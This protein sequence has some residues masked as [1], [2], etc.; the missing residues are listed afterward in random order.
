MKLLTL[1]AAVALAGCAAQ[2]SVQSSTPRS[3][4][5]TSRQAGDAQVVAQVECQKYGRH[6]RL[7]GPGSL[8][9]WFFDCVE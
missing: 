6:A 7:S 9:T 1:I 4:A 8:N 2:P 3:V 5:V